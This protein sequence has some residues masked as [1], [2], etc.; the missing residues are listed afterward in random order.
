MKLVHHTD[1]I[2]HNVVPDFDFDNPP[3]DPMQLARDLCDFMINSNALGLSANQVGL[4]YRVFVINNEKPIVCFNPKIVSFGETKVDLDEGC[5][6]FPDLYIKHSRPNQ[7]RARFTGPQGNTQTETFI[8]ITARVFQ[9][10]LD[11]LNGKTFLDDFSPL[12]RDMY[13]NKMKKAQKRRGLPR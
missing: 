7:I 5:L 13:L 6:S 3:T 11:H 12:K 10:E 2:L 1:P 4:P 9:H 8:G